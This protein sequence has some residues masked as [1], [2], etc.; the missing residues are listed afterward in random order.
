MARSF[1]SS[2]ANYL[3][4]GTTP[5][6]DTPIAISAWVYPTVLGNWP[7][8]FGVQASG[9][10]EHFHILQLSDNDDLKVA[11]KAGGS[12]LA[13][14]TTTTFSI[15]T[16]AHVC[17]I[18]AAANDRRAFKNAGG[19]GT[20]ISSGSPSNITRTWIGNSPWGGGDGWNG[21][22]AHVAFWDL[23][24]WSGATASDKADNFEIT[25]LPAL[26]KG[27]SPA[28]FN[29]GLI[30]YWPL[31]RHDND[32]VG[33]FDMTAYNTPTWAD[34]PRIIMPAPPFISFPT[35]GTAVT[36]DVSDVFDITQTLD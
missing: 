12:Y 34:Q 18:F 21:R 20:N 23:S 7:W 29:M 35:A 17:G 33:G 10:T 36:I 32:I 11:T 28:F 27:Y 24:A 9:T 1:T 30:A 5:Y 6:S 2:S 3:L 22:I 19:K 26:A 15:N 25:T 13:A 16:W 4:S 14:T 31:L 8:I